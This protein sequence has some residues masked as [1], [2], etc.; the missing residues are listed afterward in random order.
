MTSLNEH[1]KRKTW[2]AYSV[3]L[4]WASIALVIGVIG[5]FLLA[6]AGPFVELKNEQ[7]LGLPEAA[8]YETE[9]EVKALV[10]LCGAEVEATYTGFEILKEHELAG[11]VYRTDAVRGVGKTRV[12]VCIDAEGYTA[13]RTET[14]VTVNVEPTS[15]QLLLPSVDHWGSQLDYND[16][17]DWVGMLNPLVA[18]NTDL[19][20]ITY[21]WL[22]LQATEGVCMDVA[23]ESAIDKLEDAIRSFESK[24]DDV[25][26]L[27]IDIVVDVAQSLEDS[28]AQVL[29]DINLSGVRQRQALSLLRGDERIRVDSDQTVESCSVVG[30]V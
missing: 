5:G 28:R 21:M 30:E 4:R 3:K 17:A 27:D 11:K 12:A 26:W 18:E 16:G 1:R 19:I 23:W 7:S 29:K 9:V 10:S 15:V 22:Q 13:T 14:G 24:R 2:V 6:R 25:S 20:D 8:A